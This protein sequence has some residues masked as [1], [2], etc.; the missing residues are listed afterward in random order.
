M[1]RP[2]RALVRGYLIWKKR[3]RRLEWKRCFN[4]VKS[5]LS[6]AIGGWVKTAAARYLLM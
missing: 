2:V 5:S 4:V 3:E 1:D 6:A